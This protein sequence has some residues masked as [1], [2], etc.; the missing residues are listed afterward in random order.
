MTRWYR[1]DLVHLIHARAGS[2][3]ALLSALPPVIAA[4]VGLMDMRA[5]GGV[6]RWSPMDD[7]AEMVGGAMD[8]HEM[9]L[10]DSPLNLTPVTVADTQGRAHRYTLHAWDCDTR[11]WIYHPEE[12]PT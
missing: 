3:D 4:H 11:R 8:G 12:P 5:F 2:P 10:L 1:M 9:H 7:R 6:Y